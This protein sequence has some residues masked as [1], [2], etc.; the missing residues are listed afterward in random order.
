MP[1]ASPLSDRPPVV[2]AC[3]LD[4]PLQVRFRWLGDR[5][6]HDVESVSGERRAL[7]LVSDEGL[8]G[9]RELSTPA[10]QQLHCEDRPDGVRVALLVGMSGRDHW[11]LS[12]EALSDGRTLTFDAACRCS[13]RDAVCLS[14]YWLGDDRVG[15][16]VE[17]PGGTTWELAGW[18]LTT[19]TAGALPAAQLEVQP[20]RC[21]I[22]PP[23]PPHSAGAASVTWR[24]KYTIA[25]DP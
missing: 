21:T 5:F 8:E 11:S 14:R 10:L 4:A 19:V 9:A 18:R 6:R 25:L 16:P 24:W 22:R 15:A 23:P 2:L 13:A 20:S 1:K 17:S 12:V 3:R 7:M